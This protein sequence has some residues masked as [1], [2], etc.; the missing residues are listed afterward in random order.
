[1]HTATNTHACT[2]AYTNSHCNRVI[3]WPAQVNKVQERMWQEQ[4]K[5]A[6][7][8]RANY[9]PWEATQERRRRTDQHTKIKEQKDG[10]SQKDGV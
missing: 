3:S 8:L 10:A 4:K 5:M 9:Q 6:L 2:P 7:H 1:M